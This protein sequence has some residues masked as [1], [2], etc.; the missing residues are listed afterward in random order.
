MA[1]VEHV[2]RVDGV[3]PLDLEPLYNAI[4]PED[5]DAICESGSESIEL[6]FI[7]AGRTVTVA[8]E[9]GTVEVGIDEGI[10]R[11]EASD[12]ADTESPT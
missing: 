4:D 12:A 6:E 9:N 7:Y 3:D 8:K 11:A 1:I 10:S 5:L 2:A